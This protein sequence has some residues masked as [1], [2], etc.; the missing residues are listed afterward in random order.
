MTFVMMELLS[1]CR[2]AG[3]LD[4]NSGAAA[5]KGEGRWMG[6]KMEHELAHAF[7]EISCV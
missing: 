2:S 3:H 1:G 4:S 6:G 5:V 7:R